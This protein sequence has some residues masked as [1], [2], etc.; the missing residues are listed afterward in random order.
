MRG[1]SFD[2]MALASLMCI[3]LA[4]TDCFDSEGYV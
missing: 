2:P 1:R 4:I 3:D